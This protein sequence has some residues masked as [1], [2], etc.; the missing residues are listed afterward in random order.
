MFISTSL[1]DK[2]VKD[3][4]FIFAS[5]ASNIFMYKMTNPHFKNVL[6]KRRKH[7]YIAYINAIKKI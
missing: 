5:F 1:S 3:F 2:K 4:L 7:M 6:Y